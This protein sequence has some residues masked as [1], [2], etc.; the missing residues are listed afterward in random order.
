MARRDGRLDVRTRTTGVTAPDEHSGNGPRPSV[1]RRPI[2]GLG[3]VGLD[4]LAMTREE[5]YRV[6][7]ETAPPE[8]AS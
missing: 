4:T 3:L 7:F 1:E 8:R 2:A 5:Y 6:R